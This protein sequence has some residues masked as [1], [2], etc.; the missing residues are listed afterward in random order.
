MMQLQCFKS[1]SSAGELLLIPFRGGIRLDCYT[2][3]EIL[4]GHERLI[5]RCLQALRDLKSI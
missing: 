3:R 1:I 5:L 2:T 4:V